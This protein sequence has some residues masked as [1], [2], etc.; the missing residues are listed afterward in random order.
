[1]GQQGRSSP[2][3]L[4]ESCHLGSGLFSPGRQHCCRCNPWSVSLVTVAREVNMSPATT[5]GNFET[6]YSP[7]F[8]LL[9]LSPCLTSPPVQSSQGARGQDIRNPPLQLLPTPGEGLSLTMLAL[10]HTN[11]TVTNS[12]Q[13]STALGTERH[14]FYFQI[15]FINLRENSV[16]LTL[17][18]VFSCNDDNLCLNNG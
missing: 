1:M 11:R 6:P 8:P 2:R 18:T 16:F 4:E 5:A 17:I 9:H 3:A 13:M 14:R 12:L 10:H 15:D 7:P